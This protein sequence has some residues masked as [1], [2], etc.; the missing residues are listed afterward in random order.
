MEALTERDFV[1]ERVMEVE[2]V[3]PPE[4]DGL[5]LG[6]FVAEGEFVQP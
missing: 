5:L 3:K 2:G 6:V 4:G 1:G